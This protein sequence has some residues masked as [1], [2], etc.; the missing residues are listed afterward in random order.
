MV[1]SFKA[2]AQIVAEWNCDETVAAT[3]VD[4]TFVSGATS[5]TAVGGV[6]GPLGY[7][8]GCPGS[9]SDRGSVWG[10]FNTSL[11]LSRYVEIAITASQNFSLLSFGISTKR[12]SSGS[13]SNWQF[14]WS[15]DGYLSSIYATST[16]ST[17]CINHLI[18]LPP[19]TVMAGTTVSFR[20]YAHGASGAT[21]GFVLDDIQ[22]EVLNNPLPITLVSFDGE[23]AGRDT[24]LRWQTASETDNSHFT[25]LRSQDLSIWKEVGTIAGAG[26][27]QAIIDYVFYDPMPPT[28][29]SYYKLRQT[30]F[31]GTS[32]EFPQ[33]VAVSHRQIVKT[34]YHFGE[35]FGLATPSLVIDHVGRTVSPFGETHRLYQAGT[36]ILRGEDGTSVRIIVSD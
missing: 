17:S 6:T 13:P 31:D 34:H 23:M 28:G 15:I 11:D 8:L 20:I 21:Q 36:F 7:P 4:P 29:I 19:N 5:I 18:G 30:D 10:G 14:R 24:R 35:A 33:V 9:A 26:Y 2:N 12:P 1:S 3:Y 22:L 16:S 25:V 27:S 32:E